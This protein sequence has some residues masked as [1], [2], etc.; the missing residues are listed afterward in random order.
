MSTLNQAH[1]IA[2]Y[3]YFERNQNVFIMRRHGSGEFFVAVPQM[4]PE[5][6]NSGEIVEFIHQ[7]LKG[8]DID[9]RDARSQGYA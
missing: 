6:L 8:L 4:M 3:Q 2:G 9:L 5:A 1:Q 7:R